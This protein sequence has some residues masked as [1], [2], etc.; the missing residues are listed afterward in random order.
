MT[1][2]RAL[3]LFIALGV[4]AAAVNAQGVAVGGALSDNIQRFDGDP[5]LNRLDGASLGWMIVGEVRFGH[6]VARGEGS[7]DQT[8]RNAQTTTLTLNGGPATIQSELSHA[9]RDIA[10]VG[11][12]GRDIT[13]RMAFSIL[14]GASAVV[15]HRAFTTDAGQLVLI[16]PSTVPTSAV[17]TTHVDR[18]PV[19]TAEA[20]VVVRVTSHFGVAGGV[21]AQPISLADDLSGRSVR[22]F[23]GMMWRLK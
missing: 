23:V 14:G 12:Y 17:T 11:G 22:S 6:W 7:R 8:I 5:T 3:A 4:P 21:R 1:V 10:A 13:S 15:V 18:F 9:T 20:N 2:A 19:W 16:P